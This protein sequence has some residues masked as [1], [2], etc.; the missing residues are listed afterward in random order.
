MRQGTAARR[1]AIA[2]GVC[3]VAFG[4]TVFAWPVAARAYDTTGSGRPC[5]GCHPA[6]DERARSGP[7]GGYTTGTNKCA[8]CHNTHNATG[9]LLLLPAQSVRAT[10][11]VCHDGT[12]GEGVYGVLESHGIEPRAMHR[13]ETTR[14]VPG[15]AADGSS[16]ETTFSGIGFTLTCVDCHS[17][18]DNETVEPFIGD[19]ARIVGDT[20][21]TVVASSRLLRQH[22]TSSDTTVTVYGS[23]WCATCHRGEMNGTHVVNNHP[24]ENPEDEDAFTYSRVAV[25]DGVGSRD[26]TYGPLGG[27]NFGYVMPEL[28]GTTTRTPQQTGH[29]PICQQCHEDARSVGDSIA[30]AQGTIST[31]E[32]FSVGEVDTQSGETTYTG[33]NN[34]RFQ[35]FPHEGANPGLTIETGDDLCLNCHVAGD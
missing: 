17:P 25:V 8:T 27:N 16:V 29:Y 5:T 15:G 12:G 14:I 2:L 34:P 18:H 28:S 6:N 32:V 10:C 30:T 1:N 31:S 24:T 11:E 7:H 13:I 26:T 23:A 3:A 9:S 20:S 4:M 33:A 19:R 21:Q 22:P 35:T